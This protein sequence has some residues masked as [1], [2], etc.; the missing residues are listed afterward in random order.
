M[1]TFFI[2]DTHFS[3]KNILKYEPFY[4]NF[5]TIE[6]HD[7]ELIRRWNS[8][9]GNDDLVFHLGDVIFGKESMWKLAHLNGRK[10]LILGNHDHYE[11]KSY[12][13][14]FEKIYGCLKYD[15]FLILSHIPVHPN[16]LS[17]RFRYN[18]HGHLHS[19]VVKDSIGKIDER[20][21]NVSCE[22]INLTPIEFTELKKR[23]K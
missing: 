19:K 8:V 21:I 7:Q 23:M 9:V 14:Y 16:Q 22:Q 17:E 10:K 1:K 15:A 11:T 12:L 4:R 20:Y 5:D 13:Q 18:I 2:S 3:H 6:E